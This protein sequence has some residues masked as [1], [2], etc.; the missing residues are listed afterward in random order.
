MV[1]PGIKVGPDTGIG[2]RPPWSGRKARAWQAIPGCPAGLAT[3]G[4]PARRPVRKGSHQQ[5]SAMAF[6]TR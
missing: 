4:R 1:I 5:G 3:P 2:A 6:V